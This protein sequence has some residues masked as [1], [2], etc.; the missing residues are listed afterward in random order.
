MARVDA[1]PYELWHAVSGRR[2]IDEIDRNDWPAGRAADWFATLP[3][4]FR[5]PARAA[6]R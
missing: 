4:P 5:A 6:D 3:Y 1:E 2:S